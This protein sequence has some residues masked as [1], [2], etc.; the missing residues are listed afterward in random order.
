MVEVI[1]AFSWH[2]KFVPKGFSVLAPG[3][4]TCI[5]S[6]KMCIKSDFEE[7]IWNLHYMGKEKRPF[8]CHQNFVHKGL[9]AP[10][11]GAIYMYKNIK[12]Y[13]RTR[14][15]VSVYR[16]NGPLV[17]F[18]KSSEV[19]GHWF[20]TILKKHS[21]LNLHFVCFGLVWFLF[22]G[23]S[24]YFSSFRARSVNLA[25]LFLGKPLRQFTSI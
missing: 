6:L 2:P 8:C 21:N 7:I 20:Y 1:R 22:Y 17:Y 4:Y 19:Q 14:C 25:T 18:C 16:T 11:L 23:P 15:Q 10:A 3:L 9:S 13:T 12:I 5:K 24:T